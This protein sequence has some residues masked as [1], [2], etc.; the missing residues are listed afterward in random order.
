M[1]DPASP[2]RVNGGVVLKFNASQ[3][4]TTNG[5]TSAVFHSLCDAA[6]VPVQEYYNRPDLPGGS[7]LGNLLGAQVS[8]PMADIGLPQLAMHSCVELTGAKDAQ[9]L[10][11][12][13]A[14]WFRAEIRCTG[15]GCYQVAL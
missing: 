13:C 9:W 7:T 1:S 3:K 8:V 6:K 10:A 14:A 15:D 2:V 11:D 5:V 12:A 4:Y